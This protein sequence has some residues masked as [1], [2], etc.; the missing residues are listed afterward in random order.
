MNKI[1]IAEIAILRKKTGLG[2]L[3]CKKALLQV[4]GNLNQA[5]ELLMK[6]GHNFL[7]IQLNQ[8]DINEHGVVLATTNTKNN[9]GVI[10]VLTC[11]TDFVAK[12][13]VFISFAKEIL[14]I[15]LLCNNKDVI[16][17]YKIDDYM[18]KEK[19]IHYIN[20]L[21]EKIELKIFDKIYCPFVS[22]YVHHG[23]QIASLVGFT[24]YYE[25]IEEIGKNIAMQIVGTNPQYIDDQDYLNNNK[26]NILSD[27]ILLNQ[28]YI[29]NSKISVQQY[30]ENIN[31]KVKILT[32]K[33]LS[34]K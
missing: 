4:N 6:Q 16:L 7:N 18:I 20:L 29:K 24:K 25:G 22:C 11:K 23:H 1:S 21:G 14:Q 3:A 9:I 28:V 34:I 27:N 5:I 15:S 31:K 17:N 30:I 33:R 8:K 10:V 19:I 32:F 13:P 2:V 26:N 12:N